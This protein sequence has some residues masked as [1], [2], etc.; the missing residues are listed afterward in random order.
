MMIKS[1]IHLLEACV[2]FIIDSL[3]L[4]KPIYDTENDDYLPTDILDIILL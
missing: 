3:V 1:L 2:S 4:A